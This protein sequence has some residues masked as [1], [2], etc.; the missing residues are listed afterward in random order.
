MLADFGFV[1]GFRL[2]NLGERRDVFVAMPQGA[3][4][5]AGE[6]VLAFDDVTAYEA[7]RSLEVLVNDGTVASIPLD[8][9]STG[10]VVHIPLANAKP[11]QG[12]FKLTFIYSGA[13]TPDR[14]IDVRYV[15]DSLMIHP[16][17]KLALNVDFPAAP[18]VGTTAALLP[19][20][21]TL[22]LPRRKLEP[23]DIETALTLARALTG[24]GRH[25]LF[26]VGYE[27]PHDVAQDESQRVW[28]HGLIFL[29]QIDDVSGL[30]EAPLAMVAGTMPSFGTLTAVRIGGFPALVV[31]DLDSG[32]AARLFGS[33]DLSATRGVTE[34]SVGSFAAPSE[35]TDNVSFDQLGLRPAAVEVF[36]RADLSLAIAASTLPPDTQATSVL[37]ELMVAP[38]PTG[39]KAV[40]SAYVNDRLLAST[41]AAT[42]EPTRLNIALPDGLMGKIANVLAVVQRRSEQG[43]CRFQVQGYPAQILPSSQVLLKATTGAAHNFSDLTPRWA[44]GVEVLIVQQALDHPD[45]L[46]AFLNGILS[47]LSGQSAPITVKFIADDTAPAPAGPFIAISQLPPQGLIPQ[48]L[49]DR[50][51]VV[52]ADQAGHTLLNL[53]GFTGGAVAQVVSDSDE[54]GLWVHPLASDGA[55]PSPDVL[56]LD[57]GNVAFIDQTGVTL[58]MSTEH[59]ALARITYP[60][61]ISWLSIAEQFRAWIVGGLWLLATIVFLMVLQRALRRRPSPSSK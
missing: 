33:P 21:V 1:S 10:R 14:C 57:R 34:V 7:K 58:V 49:F 38:N 40:V 11:Q 44:N 3:D 48:V 47:D 56:S 20:D 35:P 26:Q 25:V 28:N 51:R 22:V 32:R 29:G 23:S 31:S 5:T 46:V 54:S 59:E 12:Y 55:L 27:K 37:L 8:G 60:D 53:G 30:L 15:G 41:V 52:V 43:D 36:G 18:D 50:G 45:T 24:S 16:E 61:Q 19:R 4:I 2:A 6:L 9:H 13:A 17:T 39:E 42:D